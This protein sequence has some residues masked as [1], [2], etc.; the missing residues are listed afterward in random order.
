[1]KTGIPSAIYARVSP[2]KHVKTPEGLHQSLEESIRICKED[3]AREGNPIVKIYIDQYVSGKNMKI[4]PDFQN[5][6][7]DSRAG[8]AC[9]WKRLYCRRVDRFGRSW[10]G[11]SKASAELIE[12]GFSLKFS[13]DGVDTDNP[14]GKGIMS[15][16]FE[17]AERKRNDI[18]EDTQRGRVRAR[19][20]G[21]IF[22]CPRKDI[23]VN[24]LRHL[25]KMPVKERPSWKSLSKTFNASPTL[26]IDRLK[27]AG[28]WD[29]IKG[30]VI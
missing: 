12:L 14:L 26:L 17:L 5:M 8:D 20:E 6:L 23:D 22:G 1:M 15:F 4:M 9:V 19:K 18:I 25:R 11:A 16:L 13:E 10:H 21:V 28:Y 30:C 29:E 3:A 27:K 24:S 7:A 2:T